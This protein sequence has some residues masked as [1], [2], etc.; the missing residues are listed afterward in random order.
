M[1]TSCR[2]PRI[3][4]VAGFAVEFGLG[5]PVLRDCVQQLAAR[6][7]DGALAARLPFYRV[8]YLA[9]RL[10]YAQMA[11]GA[12]GGTQDGARMAALARRYGGLL[13]QAVAR[14]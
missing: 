4:G 3:W 12:L 13:R 6:S 1:T 14:L 7:G 11:A 10:G 2:A 8:A 5:E 9:F